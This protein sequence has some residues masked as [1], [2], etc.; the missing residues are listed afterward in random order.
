MPIRV[1]AFVLTNFPFGPP[2]RHD[3]PGP[4]PHIA[5]CL[6]LRSA[7]TPVQL[8][9]SYTSSARH[10]WGMERLPIGVIEL[11]AVAAAALNLRPRRIDLRCL[12]RV[13][14]PPAWFPRLD[15]LDRGVV[16]WADRALQALIN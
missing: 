1:R 3:V 7:S 15:Q 16:V 12:A 2:H 13:P 9:L 5:Y 14:P 4:T 8:M 6:G 11:D 10:R